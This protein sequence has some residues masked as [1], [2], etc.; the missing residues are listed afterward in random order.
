MGYLLFEWGIAFYLNGISL[1][2][3]CD[4]AFYFNE[5]SDFS[6]QLINDFMCLVGKLFVILMGT[7]RNVEC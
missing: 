6:E 7:I 3:E 5:I 2:F 4:I 1:L